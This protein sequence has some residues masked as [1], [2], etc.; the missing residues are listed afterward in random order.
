MA[1]TKELSVEDKLRAIYDLQLIDSRIDEIRNVRGELPLEVEDLEDEVAGLGT[2]SE[3]LK[4]ELEIVEEQIKTRKNAIDDHKEA[5]KKY[6]KQQES[7]RNNREFNSLTKEVEFQE[8]EIQLAEKQIKEMKV[9]IE[10]KKEVISGLKERLESKSSHLKH[11]KSELDAIMAETQ[12]E[13]IFLSEKSAE[14]EVLIED[15]LLA[16]YK[17]I[18]TSVRN[19][20]AVVSIERGASAGSFFTIPPQT[21]VEIASRKKIITDEHSGR[22]LVD[23]ALAEEEKEK[24]D[25]LFSKF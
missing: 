13:E 12:K 4:S 11:K 24:M 25:L 18:R 19:G 9:S 1:N 10:H 16:A 2:R 6:T 5:I 15:R 20:L 14:Y 7:V 17:R 3:K 21:Q 8:L 23:S 22:I